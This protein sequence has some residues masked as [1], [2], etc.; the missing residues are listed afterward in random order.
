MVGR[1]LSV[2]T[3]TEGALSANY[4]RVDLAQPREANRLLQVR[5]GGVSETGLREAGPF[6][7]LRAGELNT[8]R[9][10]YEASMTPVHMPAEFWSGC[11]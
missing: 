8:T 9:M 7:M 1:T 4:L 3:P 6:A 10:A 11:G 5:I 2:V